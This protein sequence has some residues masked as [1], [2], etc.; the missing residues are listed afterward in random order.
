[1]HLF[2]FSASN[3][4][5][6]N[7]MKNTVKQ[8]L[9]QSIYDLETA[10]AMCQTGR[11]LYVAFMCQQSIEKH[12]KALICQKTDKMPPYIH[13]LTTL[14]EYLNLSLG[15]H[16]LDLLDILSKYYLNTRYPVIKQSLAKSLDKTNSQ[17]L[18][19]M[20]GEFLTWLKKESKI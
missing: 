13:N 9:D 15:D 14:A 1:M 18:L 5:T 17:E 2:L 16:Q 19:R 12:L 3:S 8:W 4:A 20:T 7:S 11:Y 6:H 10:K